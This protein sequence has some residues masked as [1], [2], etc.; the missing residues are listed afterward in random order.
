MFDRHDTV[1]YSQFKF[2][3][4]AIALSGRLAQLVRAPALQAGGR[5]F[6][7]CTAHQ[8]HSVIS[9][10][11]ARRKKKGGTLKVPP[12]TTFLQKLLTCQF[13]S[14]QRSADCP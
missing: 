11:I 5:R 9:P 13:R 2:R 12:I 6:E 1:R 3:K 14:K 7:S 4:L 8:I 10:S